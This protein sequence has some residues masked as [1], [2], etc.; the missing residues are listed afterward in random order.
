MKKSLLTKI[1]ALVLGVSIIV[2]LIVACSPYEVISGTENESESSFVSSGNEGIESVIKAWNEADAAAFVLGSSYAY[3]GD[4]VVKMPVPFEEYEGTFFLPAD[5]FALVTGAEYSY[6]EENENVI[7]NYGEEITVSADVTEYFDSDIT[8][9]MKE[10]AFIYGESVMLPIELMCKKTGCSMLTDGSFVAV[11]R[12]NLGKLEK[13]RSEYGEDFQ[14]MK[15]AVRDTLLCADDQDEAEED[16][17][18]TD[19]TAD[20]IWE[21]AEAPTE[22]ISDQGT[23]SPLTVSFDGATSVPLVGSLNMD[24]RSKAAQSILID[25]NEVPY[26]SAEG[27]LVGTAGSIYIED[28]KVSETE[29]ENL[30]R[31]QMK[32]YNYNGYTYGSVEVYTADGRFYKSEK[33]DPVEGLDSS[34][35]DA[36]YTDPVTYFGDVF[37]AFR[38]RDIAYATYR[39]EY[40]STVRTIDILVP[41]DGYVFITMNPKLSPYV[42]LYNSVH[43]FV[44]LYS[45][46]DDV[47]SALV[48]VVDT[49]GMK[50]VKKELEDAIIDDLLEESPEMAKKIGLVL[51]NGISDFQLRPSELVSDLSK[52]S[53]EFCEAMKNAG[54]D[55]EFMKDVIDDLAKGVADTLIK[56]ALMIVAPVVAPAF[57]AW[58]A[59]NGISNVACFIIDCKISLNSHSA[60]IV[61]GDWRKA[62]AEFLIGRGG[63]DNETFTLAYVTD[64]KTPE[65]LIFKS[66]YGWAGTTVEMYTYENFKVVPMLGDESDGSFLALYGSFV[67]YEYAGAF[68]KQTLREGVESI[69]FDVIYDGKSERLH[70]FLSNEISGESD[71]WYKYNHENVSEFFYKYKLKKVEEKFGGVEKE[72]YSGST[73]S[74]TE[75]NI[76]AVLGYPKD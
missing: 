64:D 5:F 53:G 8:S 23:E 62:Y 36:L 74:I 6:D 76:K 67:Y 10:H 19:D 32:L 44:E 72:I 25:V 30:L 59:I 65:L 75:A 51:M 31:V 45:A 41:R 63:A 52:F 15:R 56:E 43:C 20:I 18:S 60:M 12:Q 55:E 17:Q 7:F 46:T 71:V 4:E 29:Y 34:V 66:G 73:V 39:S 35:I 26:Q 49:K 9:G 2:S 37:T 57:A 11:S 24:L 47:K 61:V 42:A 48:D 27:E 28:L 13:A 69:M 14:A 22:S 58:D 16:G 21:N 38:E 1:T 68:V 50:S 40:N 3:C 33:V 70:T 54:L